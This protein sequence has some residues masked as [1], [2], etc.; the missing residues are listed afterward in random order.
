MISGHKAIFTHPDVPHSF[1]RMNEAA[2]TTA[3][4]LR[5]FPRK[6]HNYQLIDTRGIYQ[7]LGQCWASVVD[8]GP[9]LSK[10]WFNVSCSPNC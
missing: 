10:H 8:G 2:L 6:H 3:P 1:P 4:G 9:T 7:I 5:P